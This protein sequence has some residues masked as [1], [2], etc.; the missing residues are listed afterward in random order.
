MVER[1]FLNRVHR[2][3]RGRAVNQ[4]HQCPIAIL[5]RAAPAQAARDNRAAPLADVAADFLFCFLLQ[6]RLSDK[7][8][9]RPEGRSKPFGSCRISHR[10][11]AFCSL[12]R[13][14]SWSI[15]D[16]P[17]E[18]YSTYDAVGNRVTYTHTFSSQAVRTY[19][20]DAANR[21]TSVDGQAYT[22]DA[23]GRGNASSLWTCPS[24]CTASFTTRPQNKLASSGRP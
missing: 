24:S 20:Y 4:R 1:F 14:A 6:E 3:G 12:Y 9:C 2:D 17:Y 18:L 21:L 15:A 7:V 22:W 23:P 8:L 13:P 5:P 11:L 19:A 10:I 16:A